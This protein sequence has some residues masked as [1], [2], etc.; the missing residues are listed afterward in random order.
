MPDALR[1]LQDRFVGALLAPAAECPTGWGPSSGLARTSRFEIYHSAYRARLREVLATDH[2]TAAAALGS[3]FESVARAF[4]EQRPS[5]AHSLRHAGQGLADFVASLSRPDA[6][7]LAAMIRFERLLLDVFD[8]PD[9]ERCDEIVGASG[10]LLAVELHPSV[11]TC[12]PSW[13]LVE[14]WQAFKAGDETPPWAVHRGRWV[15]WRAR[16]GRTSF[17][18]AAEPEFVLLGALLDGASFP[19]AC[20]AWADRVPGTPLPK[21]LAGTLQRWVVDGLISKLA[22]ARPED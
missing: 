18:A 17:R 22:F 13:N 7:A 3:Q 10:V 14:R 21:M 20:Q 16:D 15:L 11:R 6:E 4:C 8:A 2:P 9:A 1:E 12:S 5:A 19:D